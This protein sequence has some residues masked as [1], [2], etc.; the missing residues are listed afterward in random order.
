MDALIDRVLAAGVLT[1]S[2]VVLPPPAAAADIA[3]AEKR[4]GIAIP[5]ALRALLQRWNGPDL[6]VIRFVPCSELRREPEGVLFAT[7]PAGFMYFLQGSGHIAQLDTDGGGLEEVA[8]DVND[9]L[10]GFV[11]GSRSREFAGAQWE[12]EMRR[13]GLAI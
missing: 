13:V 8:C 2:L 3:E 9:F 4:A 12:Q 7:D 6:D 5:E 11:F 10:G 1:E